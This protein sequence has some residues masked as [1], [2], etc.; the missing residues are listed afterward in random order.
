MYGS[1]SDALNAGLATDRLLAEWST[2]GEVGGRTTPW[3]DA[4]DLIETELRDGYYGAQSVRAV[5]AGAAHL[6]IEIPANVTIIKSRAP[7]AAARDWQA[8]LREAFQAA[9]SAGFVAVGFARADPSRPRYL[10]ER[11][12]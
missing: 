10:L 12:E 1:R 3:P 8:A 2:S 9:F 7:A 4:V 11:A 5:P 6:Q